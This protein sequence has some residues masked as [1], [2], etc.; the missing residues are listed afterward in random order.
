MVLLSVHVPSILQGLQHS[1]LAGEPGRIPVC[2]C[3]LRRPH[4]LTHPL[5][6]LTPQ[7]HARLRHHTHRGTRHCRD[8]NNSATAQHG[9]DQSG[10]TAGLQA[11]RLGNL[12][13]QVNSQYCACAAPPARYS[14][15]HHTKAYR[16]TRHRDRKQ[17]NTQYTTHG[18]WHTTQT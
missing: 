7:P 12:G 16:Y 13:V 6:K 1:R 18:L 9:S 17:H 4:A 2:L 3:G 11:G 8:Y 5:A 10:G 15:S 14:P